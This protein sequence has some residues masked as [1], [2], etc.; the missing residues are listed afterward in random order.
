MMQFIK[1]HMKKFRNAD[2][3]IAESLVR[4]EKKQNMQQ[5]VFSEL[6]PVQQTPVFQTKTVFTRADTGHNNEEANKIQALYRELED[7]IRMP[8]LSFT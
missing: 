7:V 5:V 2:F 6:T 4:E 8:R 1:N 3:W